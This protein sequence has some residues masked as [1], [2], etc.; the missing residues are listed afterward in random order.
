[1]KIG[2]EIAAFGVRQ[3]LVAFYEIFIVMLDFQFL[4]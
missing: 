3:V 1:M 4:S 2:L